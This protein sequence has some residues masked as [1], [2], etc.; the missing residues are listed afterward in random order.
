MNIDSAHAAS[1][2]KAG[3]GLD[4]DRRTGKVGLAAVDFVEVGGDGVMDQTAAPCHA[5]AFAQHRNE[6]QILVPIG[7]RGEMVVQVEVALGADAEV[8][9]DMLRQVLL[10][11]AF[12]NCLD[13]RHA[14]AAGD[15]D[16]RA[17]MGLAQI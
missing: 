5:V 7:Q 9:I 1:L 6:M 15:G 17:A 12:H 3:G 4:H 14:R 11:R 10:Q 16:D 8:A 13:R 2:Q